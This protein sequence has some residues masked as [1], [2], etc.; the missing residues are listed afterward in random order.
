MKTSKLTGAFYKD[1]ATRREFY[2]FIKGY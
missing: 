2:E 1:P